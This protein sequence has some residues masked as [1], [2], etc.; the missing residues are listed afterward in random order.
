LTTTV[1]LEPDDSSPPAIVPPSASTPPVTMPPIAVPPTREY[2][3]TV[4]FSVAAAFGIVVL[5]LAGSHLP[6]GI[7]T[8]GNVV[9]LGLIVGIVADL[10]EASGLSSGRDWARYA[11]TPMLWIILIAGVISFVLALAQSTIQIPIGT[12][13]AIWALRAQPAAAMGP[14][15]NSSGAGNALVLAALV[16]AALSVL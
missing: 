3:G 1:P 2:R 8:T 12:M 16:T 11:M 10:I 9:A 13:L 15:P 7:G 6:S 4:T 5:V 14:I